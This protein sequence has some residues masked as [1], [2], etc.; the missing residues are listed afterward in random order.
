MRAAGLRRRTGFWP[1][2]ASLG[3]CLG[4]ASA[5]RGQGGK[6][7]PEA[8]P[9]LGPP[10]SQA[11]AK[12][13]QIGQ[14]GE[15]QAPAPPGAFNPLETRVSIRVKEAPLATFLDSISAQAKVNF[16]ITE[17]LEQKRVT[18]F[19]QNVTVREALQIL[20]EIKGLTYQQIGRSNT[21][22][23]SPR[24]KTAPNRIT[25]IYNL[26]HIPLIPL[27]QSAGQA[28]A[29]GAVPAAPGAVQPG[30]R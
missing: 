15:A 13:V 23:V 25:R 10:A 6:A 9:A 27:E 2:W 30:Q 28:V 16:I 11:P 19:L 29:S 4:L 21:Y 24:S 3:L 26:S 20:L 1:W 22:V 8:E 7:E 12:P 17:G 18:A 14:T 5:A